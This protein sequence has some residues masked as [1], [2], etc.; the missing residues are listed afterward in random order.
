M[1]KQGRTEQADRREA[2]SERTT[3]QQ[4]LSQKEAKHQSH[5]GNVQEGTRSHLVILNVKDD[6]KI[7]QDIALPKRMNRIVM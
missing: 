1:S 3:E 4:A 6:Q 7:F 2:Q 5:L